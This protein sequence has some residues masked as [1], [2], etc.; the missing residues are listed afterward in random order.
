MPQMRTCTHRCRFAT[1][2]SSW[3]PLAFFSKK[4]SMTEM[5]YST[6][7]R[8]PIA[9]FSAIKHFRFFP[10]RS[11]FHTFYLSQAISKSKTPFTSR[12]RRQLAFLSVFTSI[13]VHL[14]G[15][16]NVVADTLV[17]TISAISHCITS[18]TCHPIS[19]HR[20]TCRFHKSFSSAIVLH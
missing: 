19:S 8:E 4:L 12:Q 9:V 13:F 5:R 17:T 3:Q 15:H 7:D 18:F 20:F 2:Q 10:G 11:S 6:F 1:T 14:P 16:Q